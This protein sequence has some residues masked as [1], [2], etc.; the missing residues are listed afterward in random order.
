MKIQ[1]GMEKRKKFILELMGD[2]L[3]KPMRLREIAS[4]LGLTKPEKKELYEI[5]ESLY[6]E[7]KITVDAKGRYSLLPGRKNRKKET[8]LKNRS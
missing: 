8:D 4:L 1:K 5:L 6:E 3:Y 2:R 7:R